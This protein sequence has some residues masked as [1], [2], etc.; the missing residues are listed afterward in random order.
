MV[1]AMT[2]P[3]KPFAFRSFRLAAAAAVAALAL[4]G[5]YVVPMQPFGPAPP[6]S[7]TGAFA[8]MSPVAQT[9]P[10][11]LYPSNEQASSYGMVTGTVTNDLNGRGYF[12]AAIGGEQF[13]GEATRVAGS[14]RNGIANAS[15]SRGGMLVCRYTMNSATLGTGDCVLNGGAAFKM[16]VG[17]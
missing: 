1:N 7:Q 10:A 11:R 17:S 16:H 3:S 5:C 9:F 14:Q 2:H 8:P 12:T 15:G 6:P 4:T 13:Q